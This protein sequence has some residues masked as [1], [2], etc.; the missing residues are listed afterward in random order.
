MVERAAPAPVSAQERA[1]LSY[2]PTHLA[3]KILQSK[4]TFLYVDVVLAEE[5]A[6][7]SKASQSIIADIIAQK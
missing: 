7:F 1:P 3:E 6:A 5:F 4:A 2:M